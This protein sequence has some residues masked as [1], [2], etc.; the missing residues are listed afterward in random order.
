ML[1]YVNVMLSQAPF[2]LYFALWLSEEVFIFCKQG[3]TQAMIFI[4]SDAYFMVG[5]KP[6][7]SGLFDYP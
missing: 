7:L 4:V 6:R 2:T 3:F 5:V 1:H